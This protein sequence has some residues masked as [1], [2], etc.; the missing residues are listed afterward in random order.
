MSSIVLM[1]QFAE[2]KARINL[3]FIFHISV[4]MIYN[5]I[6][7]ACR[8]VLEEIVV[9]VDTVLRLIILVDS[10]C[11]D[12]F[13]MCRKIEFLL[14]YATPCRCIMRDKV[15]EIFNTHLVIGQS[16]HKSEHK[17]RFAE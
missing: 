10:S 15:V 12:S 9:S 3:P 14:T 7:S 1:Y 4:N 2:R 8:T 5:H 13:L 11:Y 16:E 17:E 6:P